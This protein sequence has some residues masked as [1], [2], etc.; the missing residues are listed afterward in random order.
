MKIVGMVDLTDP[1]DN[2]RDLLLMPS[3]CIELFPSHVL[4]LLGLLNALVEFWRT[5]GAMLLIPVDPFGL[6]LALHLCLCI[7]YSAV[8]LICSGLKSN[9]RAF[10]QLLLNVEQIA[11][12]SCSTWWRIPLASSLVDWTTSTGIPWMG[13]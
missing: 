1:M 3:G 9:A 4:I 13:P 10:D 5:A 6:L 7:E 12:R 8:S 11:P 2:L